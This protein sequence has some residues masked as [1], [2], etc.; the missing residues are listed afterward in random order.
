MLFAGN[1]PQEVTRAG[2]ECTTTSTR[3]LPGGGGSG[4]RRGGELEGG[5]SHEA[6]P[7]LGGGELLGHQGLGARLDRQGQGGAHGPPAGH[8]HSA[9]PGAA[10]VRGEGGARALAPPPIPVPVGGARGGGAVGVPAP[11]VPPEAAAAAPTAAAPAVLGPA[12]RPRAHAALALVLVHEVGVVGGGATET[13]TPPWR[14]TEE[15]R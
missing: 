10:L 14:R 11:P 3:S 7:R 5:V 9:G 1:R 13:G 6:H 12:P 15:T 2:C 8:R 4:G